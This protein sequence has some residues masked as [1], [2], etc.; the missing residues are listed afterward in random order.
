MASSEP[1]N[2]WGALQGGFTAGPVKQ[3]RLSDDIQTVE[4]PFW[5]QKAGSKDLHS[6]MDSGTSSTVT[7]ENF[8][9]ALKTTNE[10]PQSQLNNSSFIG[11]GDVSF[12]SGC[13]Q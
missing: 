3:A 4:H 6:S 7:E 12:Q 10:K 11:F 9:N 1:K 2:P 8:T 13:G 5:P